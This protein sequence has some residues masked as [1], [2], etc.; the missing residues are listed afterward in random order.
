MT[1]LTRHN[2][3]EY[4][5]YLKLLSSIPMPPGWVMVGHV[6]SHPILDD[7]LSNIRIP[8]VKVPEVD[9]LQVTW[10]QGDF[11]ALVKPILS[12]YDRLTVMGVITPAQLSFMIATA[13]TKR[14]LKEGNKNIEKMLSS[15]LDLPPYQ[16]FTELG[17]VLYAGNHRRGK[18]SEF[19]LKRLS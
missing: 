11:K 10:S 13:K 3:E 16:N 14:K 7:V 15:K 6:H 4:Y 18:V 9:G 8:L 5:Q 12:G 2:Q 17:I 19:P 1:S